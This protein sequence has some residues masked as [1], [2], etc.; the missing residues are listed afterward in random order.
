MDSGSSSEVALEF[1][2]YFC[3]YKD[4]RVE[5]FFGTNVV[6]PS[7]DSHG[8]TATKDV[9]IVQETGL[10]AR[11][12][13]PIYYHGGGFYMAKE[14]P[15]PIGYEDSWVALRWVASHFTGEGPEAWLR[16]HVDFQHVFLAGDSMGGNIVHNMAT[17]AGV[18]GLPGVRLLGICLVHPYFARKETDSRLSRLGCSR[19]L[20]FIAEKDETRDNGL[21]YYE[22]LRMSGWGGVVEIVEADGEEHVFHLFRP[23]C[24]KALALLKKLASFIDQDNA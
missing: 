13:T 24:E 8:G 14:H 21:F 19:V 23:N 17:R 11:I 5:R 12:F 6:P 1:L 7:I 20:I 2:P 10:I 16:E 15:V 3:A 22:T 18:E 4:G 9:Q